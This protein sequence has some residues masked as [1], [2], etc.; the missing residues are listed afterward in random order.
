GSPGN[1]VGCARP[2][3]AHIWALV[4]N[5]KC[6]GFGIVTPYFFRTS[7]DEA[8]RTVGIA[9]G[10]VTLGDGYLFGG[11][12]RTTRRDGRQCDIIFPFKC[13][14]GRYVV[15]FEFLPGAGFPV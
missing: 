12:C 13:K 2:P 5:L 14:A 1:V 8:Q 6:A 7:G 4:A 10:G 15:A 9:S 3:I 11:G